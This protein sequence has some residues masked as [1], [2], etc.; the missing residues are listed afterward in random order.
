MPFR[1]RTSKN[2]GSNSRAAVVPTWGASAIAVAEAIFP[3]SLGTPLAHNLCSSI[4]ARF[5]PAS[6]VIRAIAS[7]N[8]G[9]ISVAAGY[10]RSNIERDRND[11]APSEVDAEKFVRAFAAARIDFGRGRIN[12]ITICIERAEE[13]RFVDRHV[14]LNAFERVG[15]DKK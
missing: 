4:N 3:W 1:F 8:V 13:T 10:S 2:C 12:Q 14:G 9:L 5:S 15:R 11:T 6:N 7:P